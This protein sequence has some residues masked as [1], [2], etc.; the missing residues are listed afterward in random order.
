MNIYTTPGYHT[1]SGRR[2]FTECE[3]YSVTERCWTSI[4]GSRIQQVDGRYVNR[5]GWMFNSLTYVASPR[6]VWRGNPLATPGRH[7]VDGRTWVTECDTP[8]TGRNGCR[9]YILAT[10][11]VRAGGPGRYTYAWQNQLVLNNI[12]LF[13]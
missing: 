7:I 8:Q 11:I 4:W 1:S 9:S 3:A 6:S 13:S 2:W 12:V 5:T 10:V